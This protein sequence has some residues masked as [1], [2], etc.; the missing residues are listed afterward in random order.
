M[1][2]T[3]CIC[4]RCP[5]GL[6]CWI[7]NNELN[8]H[9]LICEGCHGSYVA[10]VCILEE[11][12]PEHADA[13]REIIKRRDSEAMEAYFDYKTGAWYKSRREEGKQRKANGTECKNQAL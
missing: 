9:L 7:C 1:F 2:C 3:E 11:I 4:H 10:D 13:L 12:T 8:G 5:Y 6:K